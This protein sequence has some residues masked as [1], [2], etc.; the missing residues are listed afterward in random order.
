MYTTLNKIRAKRPCS[1]GWEKLL[2]HLGKTQADDEPLNIATVLDSNGLADALWCLSAVEGHDREI[3]LY[4]VW[5]AR[6]AQHLMTDARSINALDVAERFANG[7]ASP[8]QLAVAG[9]AA[10][11]V[12]A[13][14]WAAAAA[15]WA[16]AEEAAWAAGAAA[17]EAAEEAAWAQA[18]TAQSA[19]LREICQSTSAP[20]PTARPHY[21][22]SATDA[23]SEGGLTD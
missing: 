8:E 5:C 3:R 7:L 6:Q 11:A 9:A 13:A 2:R 10:G 23:V 18:Q 21:E 12:R 4:A 16:A 17:R 19:K 15:A 14:G 1:Y 22:A 20:V